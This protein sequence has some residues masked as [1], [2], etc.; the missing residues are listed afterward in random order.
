MNKTGLHLHEQLMLLALRDEKG[1]LHSKAGMY[2]FALGGAILSELLLAGCIEIEEGKKG[3]VSLLRVKRLHEPL[4]DECLDLIAS[5]KRERTAS[6]WVHRFAKVKRLRHRVAEGL[7]RRGILRNKETKVLL[8]FT[9]KVYPE[10]DPAP[11]RQVRERL[12]R[13][14]FGEAKTL[15]P[16]TGVLVALAHGTGLLRIHFE[17]KELKKRKHRLDQIVKGDMVGKATRQAVQ[18]AQAA[19]MAAIT[20]ATVAS[21]ASTSS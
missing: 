21:T 3:K 17:R 7:S 16:E 19:A 18:A 10:V 4:L 6:N 1:T 15:K 11:E 5:A 14:I 20:A 2:Q 8:F 12:R 9:R 13:A